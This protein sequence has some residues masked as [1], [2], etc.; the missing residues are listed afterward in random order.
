MNEYEEVKRLRKLITQAIDGNC[1]AYEALF[2]TLFYQ[3]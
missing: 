3:F 2:Y 1:D